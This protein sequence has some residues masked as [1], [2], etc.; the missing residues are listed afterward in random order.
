[1][2][3]ANELLYM[4]RV[5]HEVYSLYMCCFSAWVSLSVT[6]LPALIYNSCCCIVGHSHRTQSA[7]CQYHALTYTSLSLS[8]SV[9]HTT[10]INS[11]LSVL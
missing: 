10:A 6:Q 1:M 8:V 7:L 9:N 3:L 11:K 2:H 5:K 4:R